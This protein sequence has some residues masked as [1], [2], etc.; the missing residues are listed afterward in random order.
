MN[1]KEIL[2]GY[3]KVVASPEGKT[4]E[5]ESQPKLIRRIIELADLKSD[6]RVLDIGAGWGALTLAIA[7][8]VNKVIAVDPSRKNLDVAEL[9]A[10]EKG[11]K[12]IEFIVGDFLQLTVEEK[13]DNIV[14]SIA[15]HHVFDYQ[16]RA[17]EIFWNLLKDEGKVVLCDMDLYF[18]DPEEEQEKLNENL[19]SMA[20]MMM[21]KSDYDRYMEALR[22]IAQSDRFTW[23]DVKTWAR[24]IGENFNKADDLIGLFE[25]VGFKIKTIEELSPFS[26]IICA[27]K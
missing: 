23:K 5:W 21:N 13:V 1:G 15:F 18:F 27:K 3:I 8:L 11:L 6:S 25:E 14:S 2:D 7:P 22:K 24:Q 9:K 17:I 20:G 12:N 19:R 10:N 26:G 16:R 4:C